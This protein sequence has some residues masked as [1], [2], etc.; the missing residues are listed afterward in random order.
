MWRV[1]NRQHTNL[2]LIHLIWCFIP[3]IYISLCFWPLLI[4]LVCSYAQKARQYALQLVSLQ[5]ASLHEVNIFFFIFFS[6]NI[7]AFILVSLFLF[8]FFAWACCW[9][10]LNP[11]NKWV[12]VTV[13]FWDKLIGFGLVYVLHSS[14]D[15]CTLWDW[16]ASSLIK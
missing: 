11:F 13:L 4:C 6:T 7:F 10:R 14:M 8:L 12:W 9:T 15:S 16:M 5:L 1:N 2:T 3:L